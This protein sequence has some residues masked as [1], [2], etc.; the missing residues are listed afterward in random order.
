MRINVY[1]S[2]KGFCSRREADRWI[3]EGKVRIND[4]L[5]GIGDNVSDIDQVTVD[6]VLLAKTVQPVYLLLNKP[7]GIESTTD[8]KKPDNLIDFVRYPERIFPVG[9]LDKD[10][11]GL[12]LLTNDGQIVNQILREEN[13]HEKEYRVLVDKP[14]TPDFLSQMESGVQIYNP[15]RRRSECTKPCKIRPTAQK[16]FRI[17]L[18]QGLNLQIRRMTKAL[19]YRVMEL[20]RTRIMH[21]QDPQLPVGKWRHLTETETALLFRH[22]AGND[23]QVPL[24]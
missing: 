17:I 11:S 22:I 12:L 4:H 1:I 5:A 10:T 7:R 6:G 20:E 13:H 8:Q 3:Q 16:E 2:S 21:L 14:L 19:G 9:R 18:T 24:N 15:V 23:L